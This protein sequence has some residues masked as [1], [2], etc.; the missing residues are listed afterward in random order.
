[1]RPHP[2]LRIAVIVFDEISPFHLSVPCMVFGKDKLHSIVPEFDVM[3]CSAERGPLKT[4]AGFMIDTHYDLKVLAQADI[5]IVPS[6]RNIDEPAPM[7]LIT[8]LRK[9]HKRGALIIGLCLGTFVLAQAGLLD[10]KEAA[11]H[12]GWADVLTERYPAVRVNPCVLYVDEGSI[13]TSAGVAAG[14]D[15]CL[16]VLRKQ[17]GMEVANCVAR[18]MVVSPHR[19]GGQAQYIASPVRSSIAV[20]RFAQVTEWMM[21]HLVEPQPLDMLAE[22]A[23]MSRRSFTRKFRQATGTTISQ[24][25]TTQRLALAQ[26]LL[27][28]TTMSIEAIAEKSGFGSALSLRQHFQA[29][30]QTSPSRYRNEFGNS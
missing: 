30:F 21:A 25:L 1:M 26:R 11:T 16:H 7:Q 8:A 4:S 6:W 3:V 5:V 9:A 12:W 20:D 24:W 10:G 15:C 19:Q 13:L 29:Q 28:T 22:R 2:S 18:R 17:F 14:I 23:L 27:E